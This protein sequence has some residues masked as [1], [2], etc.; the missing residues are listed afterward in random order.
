M[1]LPT[2][3]MGNVN[4]DMIKLLPELT[5]VVKDTPIIAS[6][7]ATDPR[8]MDLCQL[9]DE[10]AS[11]GYSGVLNYPTLSPLLGHE[12]RQVRESVGLGFGR[13][14]QMMRAARKKNLFTIA[15]TFNAEDAKHMAEAGVDCLVAHVGS[16]RG[17][18]AGFKSISLE[19][20]VELVQEMIRVAKSIDPQIICLAHGGPFSTPED[21][22]Y[23]YQH[24]DVVGFVGA[25]S[26]ERIPIE[27]A[28]REAVIQFKSISLPKKQ[29]M[30]MKGD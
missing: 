6:L 15:Y 7:E 29:R 3:I 26:I 8:W 20:G 28:V 1:G 23:L 24:T 21:T 4:E 10:V 9:I 30:G 11:V 19:E 14:V 22:Q 18:L 12:R 27:K 25:S 13:E 16:T 17:G 2:T 5:N